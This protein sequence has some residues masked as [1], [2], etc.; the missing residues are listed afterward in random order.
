MKKGGI[1]CLLLFLAF[2][3]NTTAE[4]TV[5]LDLDKAVH[6]GLYNNRELKFSGRETLIA[7]KNLN[8]KYRNFFPELKLGYSESASVAYYNPDSHIKKLSAGLSQEIYDRGIKKAELNIGKKEL[9]IEKLKLIESEEDF[10]FQVITSF[11]EILRLD[12]ELSILE[13]TY[14]N[15]ALQIEIARKELE[16]GE[17][18][19][20]SFLEMDIAFRNIGI[21]LGKKKLEKDKSLF[22]FSR[23]L[24]LKPETSILLQGEI[25]TEYAGFINNDPDFF[26]KALKEQSTS[27]REK[28]LARE[29]AHENLESVK[30]QNIP[31]IKADCSFSMSGEMFPLTEPGLDISVTFSFQKPGFPGS[32]SAGI[33]KEEFERSRTITAEA[34]PLSSL[35]NWYSEDS[36]LL[37][38]E[39]AVW[40]IENFRISNEF[41]V[42]EMLLEIDS[43]K[44]ELNLLKKKLRISE[45][46]FSIEQLQLRLGE[47]KRID[48]IESSI[49]LSKER[50]EL[51]NSI[52]ELY[53]KE[54]TLLRLCGIKDIIK[55][56][57][58]IIR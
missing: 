24:T 22:S 55:T 19:E 43:A 3:H 12:K 54:I 49:E 30:R 14:S 45:S 40:D 11:K 57:G 42:R 7:G 52:T 26:I 21:T 20:L 37:G 41:S 36:A 16:L 31:D 38:L 28:I 10:T 27:Y 2:N 23:L 6:A 53:Q 15:T 9:S 44:Q 5:L 32:V 4:E 35:E 17:I 56:G 29:K 33:G 58:M 50:I 1:L 18:T 13:E 8:L 34:K 25:N 46:K 39:K 51:L 48:Y 47:I